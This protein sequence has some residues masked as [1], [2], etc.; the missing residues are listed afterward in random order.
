EDDASKREKLKPGFRTQ[1]FR[2]SMV[3]GVIKY[4][5]PIPTGSDFVCSTRQPGMPSSIATDA[6]R[7]NAILGK[8]C[9]PFISTQVD[10]EG[11]AWKDRY[12]W[13]RM[14]PNNGG[15]FDYSDLGTNAA[16]H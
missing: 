12:F 6:S 15:Q 4:H 11:S 16:Y 2:W 8:M 1:P 10:P 3:G 5:V 9:R 7:N 14:T 13:S